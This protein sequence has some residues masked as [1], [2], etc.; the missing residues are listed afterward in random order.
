MKNQPTNPFM[1]GI[2]P[3]LDLIDFAKKISKKPSFLKSEFPIDASTR[4]GLLKQI[5]LEWFYVSALSYEIY[6]CFAD[7]ITTR[8]NCLDVKSFNGILTN[9][10]EWNDLRTPTMC[11]NQFLIGLL[12][13]L[14]SLVRVG[15]EKH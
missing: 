3:K 6:E 2:L 5:N 11:P 13:D 15:L 7:I 9:I 14:R 4:K 12:M 1:Q 8:Y 10:Y